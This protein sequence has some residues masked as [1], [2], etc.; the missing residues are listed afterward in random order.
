MVENVCL[1]GLFHFILTVSKSGITIYYDYF[2]FKEES[3]KWD[4]YANVLLTG[5]GIRVA[6]RSPTTRSKDRKIA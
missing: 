2:H 6:A 3:E 4:A 1:F 5:E